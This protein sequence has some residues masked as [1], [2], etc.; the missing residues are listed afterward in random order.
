[1][2]PENSFRENINFREVFNFIEFPEGCETFNG[3][4]PLECYDSLWLEVGCL[5]DGFAYPHNREELGQKDLDLLDLKYV[6]RYCI[7]GL[8][9]LSQY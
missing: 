4:N 3:P 7:L 1:M 6:L 9:Y 8:N 2:L 5:K